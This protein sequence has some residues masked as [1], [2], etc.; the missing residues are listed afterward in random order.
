MWANYCN[1]MIRSFFG[2]DSFTNT[3]S[4]GFFLT[5]TL[6]AIKLAGGVSL[7]SSSTMASHPEL[8]K[9]HFYE[10]ISTSLAWSLIISRP[11]R[12]L[13]C[14]ICHFSGEKNTNSNSKRIST[15]AIWCGCCDFFVVFQH[16][17]LISS[18]CLISKAAFLFSVMMPLSIY[19]G[20]LGMAEIISASHFPLSNSSSHLW[21]SARQNL[22]TAWIGFGA[23]NVDSNKLPCG[24]R[25]SVWNVHLWVAER[26]QIPILVLISWYSVF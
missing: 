11:Q 12:S 3:T 9:H 8:P 19:P 14:W 26:I 23:F 20:H 2:E 17:K 21:W 1:S 4:L 15:G 22:N 25:Y 16:S 24:V 13:F 7:N 18:E 10:V 6:V 5:G